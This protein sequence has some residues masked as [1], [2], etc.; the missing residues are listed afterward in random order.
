M[1]DALCSLPR[2]VLF[3][4][5]RARGGRKAARERRVGAQKGHRVAPG[6]AWSL[7]R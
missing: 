2:H 4:K 3:M 6:A 5:V 7:S 1:E